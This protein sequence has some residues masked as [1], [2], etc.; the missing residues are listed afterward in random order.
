MGIGGGSYHQAEAQAPRKTK[1]LGEQMGSAGR[2][3]KVLGF[4]RVWC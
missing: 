1:H 3:T 2:K 4:G